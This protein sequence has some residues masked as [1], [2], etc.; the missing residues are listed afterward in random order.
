MKQK[1]NTLKYSKAFA[2]QEL[3]Q[4][5]SSMPLQDIGLTN[6]NLKKVGR[7]REAS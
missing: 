3:I 4:S 6:Q 7:G 5:D 1:T 2:V